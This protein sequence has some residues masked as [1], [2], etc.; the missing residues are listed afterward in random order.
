MDEL[1]MRGKLAPVGPAVIGRQ[2]QPRACAR[3]ISR[4]P[5]I[6]GYEWRLRSAH[7]AA[8]GGGRRPGLIAH[9]PAEV[10]LIGEPEIGRQARQI[11]L[12]LRE[13]L[14]RGAHTQPH[15]MPRDRV[16]V[17]GAED[18]AQMMW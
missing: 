15:A 14:E 1:F 11:S 3:T 16:P 8:K 18:A 13:T 2:V 5:L 4:F 10:A 9:D 12:A 6:R 17:H 7:R